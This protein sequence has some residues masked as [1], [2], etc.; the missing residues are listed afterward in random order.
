MTED[1]RVTSHAPLHFDL[2]TFDIYVT[3]KAG[4]T[5]VLIPEKLSV[6]PERLADLLQNERISVNRT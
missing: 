2:S 1:D 6:F 5:V 3:I 4:G